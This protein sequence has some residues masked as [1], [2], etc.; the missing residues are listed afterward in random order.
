M[1]LVI[2]PGSSLPILILNANVMWKV[3]W[4][5]GSEMVGAGWNYTEACNVIKKHY[6]EGLCATKILQAMRSD[7]RKKQYPCAF[8]Y[9]MP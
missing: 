8:E 6:G 9:S 7:R 3:F 4:V 5:K 1:D 2:G